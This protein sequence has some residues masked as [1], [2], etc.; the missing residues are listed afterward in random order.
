M[1]LR[2]CYQNHTLKISN[3]LDFI[4]N[5]ILWKID[6]KICMN[7]SKMVDFIE[8]NLAMSEGSYGVLPQQ[9]SV[10]GATSQF[11]DNHQS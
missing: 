1:S 5:K 2:K 9:D 7:F 8:E 11:V 3:I 4:A 10:A 6:R